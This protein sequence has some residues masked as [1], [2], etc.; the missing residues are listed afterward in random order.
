M[1]SV[2]PYHRTERFEALH[3][4]ILTFHDSTFECI[5][6]SFTAKVFVGPLQHLLEEIDRLW[7]QRSD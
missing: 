6:A 1:N 7:Q 5:A 3:H 4:F 2:H